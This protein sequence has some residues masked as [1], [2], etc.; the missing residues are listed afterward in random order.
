[1][2]SKYHIGSFGSYNTHFNYVPGFEHP[3]ALCVD[4]LDVKIEKIRCCAKW[5]KNGIGSTT[6]GL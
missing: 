6:S 5:I 3:A 2:N 1:M 4:Q